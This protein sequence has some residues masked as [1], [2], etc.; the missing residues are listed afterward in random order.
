MEPENKKQEVTLPDDLQE[1]LAKATTN[2]ERN[3][4]MQEFAKRQGAETNMTKKE[5]AFMSEEQFRSFLSKVGEVSAQE[6][7]AAI[8]TVASETE[9]KYNLEGD[10]A[11][12]IAER[13]FISAETRE[14]N[15]RNDWEISAKVFRGIYLSRMGKPD[16]YA[17]AIEEEAEYCKRT[18]N[19]ETRAMSLG[20]DST[21]G[22]LSP[23][24]FSTQLYENLARQS[25]V[26]RYATIIPMNGN[27][28]IRLPQLTSGLAAS[29]TAEAA[30]I[31]P[32]Q[33]VFTQKTLETKKIATLSQP[34]SIELIEKANPIIVPLL[35]RFATM[36][37]SKKEDE[38]VFATTGDGIRASSTNEVTGFSAATGYSAVNFDYMADLEG[39]LEAQYK[40]RDD[41]TGSG[42]ITGVAR[43]WTPH[44]LENQLRK[45]KEDDSSN[46]Y[47]DEARKLR[48]DGKI[49]GYENRN[50]LSLP[51]GTSLA[52][53]DKVAVFGN[54]AHVW[55]GIEPGFR[56]SILEEGLVGSVPLGETA[57]VAV[58]VL[59]FFDHV[60]IDE[61]AFSQLKLVA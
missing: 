31:S 12:V 26:R 11:K 46:V 42:M 22:Y 44:R 47:L 16:Q 50:A 14:R 20:T 1:R 34:I 5:A 51:D 3:D 39:E 36:E 57:Q 18:Y 30:A 35:I 48:N 41:I 37:M 4:V 25:H 58:R 6:A 33:A 60:V 19:R 32:S 45:A 23:E 49:F 8:A 59:E 29:Q 55:A 24:L 2:E 53:N 52:V 15:K 21:G 28:V 56:I 38:L 61:E 27:E 9:R 10:E 7:K 17:R 40:S 54:L 13:S 43:Y